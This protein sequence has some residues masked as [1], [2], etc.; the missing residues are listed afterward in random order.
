MIK[1]KAI[2]ATSVICILQIAIVFKT[3][4]YWNVATESP[5]KVLVKLRRKSDWKT[6][7]P[8]E[9][10]YQPLMSGMWLFSGRFSSKSTLQN[11]IEM[12]HIR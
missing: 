8:V 12:V 7:E 6:S 11:D 3:P 5:V 1:Q 9:F 10:T 2:Y 4:A